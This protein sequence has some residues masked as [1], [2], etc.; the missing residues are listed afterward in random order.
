MEYKVVV[1]DNVPDLEKKV[2]DLISVDWT[3]LG[4]VAVTLHSGGMMYS[5]KEFYQAMVR[6][7]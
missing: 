1:A 3:P 4:G 2:R 6:T 7:K 5:P